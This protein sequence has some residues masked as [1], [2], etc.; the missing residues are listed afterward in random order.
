MI[1]EKQQEAL[2][3]VRNLVSFTGSLYVP[4]KTFLNKFKKYLGDSFE[5]MGREMG[6]KRISDTEY[7]ESICK[8]SIIIT[9]CEQTDQQGTDL[10]Y[11]NQMV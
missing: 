10:S 7:W 3:K 11:I 4:R 2:I 6:G 5:I 1:R 8:N 9:T